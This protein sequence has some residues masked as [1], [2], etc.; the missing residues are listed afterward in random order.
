MSR[1]AFQEFN[2][3]LGGAAAVRRPGKGKDMTGKDRVELLVKTIDRAI[4][5]AE[6]LGMAHAVRV[7]MVARLEVDL[8]EIASERKPDVGAT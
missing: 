2:V 5:Q 3:E 8:S 1:E 7:L 6:D 4:T